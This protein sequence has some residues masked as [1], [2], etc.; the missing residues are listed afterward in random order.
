MKIK[1][2]I[3]R[4]CCDDRRNDLIRVKS[5]KS[6]PVI[7]V[8]RHCGQLWY[9]ERKW[10]GVDNDPSLMKAKDYSVY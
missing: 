6:I 5:P 7:Y 3:E 2:V 10:N 9:E 8:C 4:E 1:E